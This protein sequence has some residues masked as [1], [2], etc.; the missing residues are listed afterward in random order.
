LVYLETF[1]D[2]N[3]DRSIIGIS[4]LNILQV[5]NV[6]FYLLTSCCH[7]RIG[8]VT[9]HIN[10]VELTLQIQA[11]PFIWKCSTPL[12]CSRIAPHLQ[13]LCYV[14]FQVRKLFV[15]SYWCMQQ[16][17]LCIQNSVTHYC[18]LPNEGTVRK[19]DLWAGGFYLSC[20]LLRSSVF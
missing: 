11:L 14:V 2:P 12:A 15:L 20:D 19:E 7:H 1:L 9:F 5:V 10:I 8:E 3:N 16:K 17:I 13:S 6:A 18:Y 4:C